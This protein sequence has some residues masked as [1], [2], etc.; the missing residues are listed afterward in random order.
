MDNPDD[1]DFNAPTVRMPA[2]FGSPT[3]ARPSLHGWVAQM[4][5][6]HT[7]RFRLLLAINVAMTSLLLLFLVLDYHR[8]MAQRLA[9]KHLA[10]EEEATI[11]LH[12]IVRLRSQGAAIVQQYADEVCGHMHAARSPGHHIAVAYG[13]IFIQAK[14]HGRDSAAMLEAMEAGAA[15][16]THQSQ[17]H[18]EVLVVGSAQ[19]EGLT[20][21]VAEYL[22]N[23]LR[24]LRRE[25]L[26]RLGQIVVL[27][28]VLESVVSMVLVR[29]V[30]KPLER[31][32]ATVDDI[33]RGQLGTQ[34]AA[35][36][37]TELARLAQAINSMSASLADADRDR[38]QQMAKAREI[39]E[40][41]LPREVTI[42]GLRFVHCYQPADDVT[43]DHFDA[44]PLSDGSWLLCVADVTGHGVPAAMSAAMLKTLLE[45]ASEQETDVSR[46][47]AVVNRRFAK[48]SPCG[49]FVTMFL[50]RWQPKASTLEY[51]SAGHETVWL[52][53]ASGG[54]LR[55]LSATGPA[56]AIVEDASWTT[57]T[58]RVGAGDRLLAVSDGITEAFSPQ[59]EQ[60]G[61]QRLGELFFECRALALP[62]SVKRIQEEV[63]SH[64]GGGAPTDDTTLLA[65]GWGA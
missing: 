19:Q 32:Q 48:L 44:L 61:R 41:L 25:V 39:Q 12:S 21:F 28:A 26:L 18:G 9:E 64:R 15:S 2:S 62:D 3:A 30:A 45:H 50:A 20:V 31:L 38:R 53:P 33:G 5:S 16:R 11:L 36:K 23:V 29:M 34:T 14:A 58:V 27:A 40:H 7:I 8:E 60:F 65:I 6:R 47:L 10:M 13:G 42:P 35:F 22:T 54:S 51:G 17:L 4:S 43:G 49:D 46:I 37:S 56:L 1:G 24:S 55:E 59:G 57:V 52:L 63:A